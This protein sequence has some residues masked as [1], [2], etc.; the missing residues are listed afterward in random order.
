MTVWWEVYGIRGRNPDCAEQKRLYSIHRYSRTMVR[1]SNIYLRL[2][3][4]LGWAKAHS[5]SLVRRQMLIKFSQ[6]WAKA[7]YEKKIRELI[8]FVKGNKTMPRLTC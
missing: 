8:N 7:Q 5:K 2:M 1:D 4:E 3:K 6:K